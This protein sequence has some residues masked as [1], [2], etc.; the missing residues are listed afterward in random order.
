[1]RF[2]SW[3]RAVGQLLGMLVLSWLA[4]AIPAQSAQAVALVPCPVTTYDLSGRTYDHS[5]PYAAAHSEA[6]CD[7][8]VV[9]PPPSSAQGPPHLI[10]SVGFAANSD[11]LIQ[12]AN[13]DRGSG[14][15]FASE[16]TSPSGAKY[17]DVNAAR[18]ALPE[19][20]PL[21]ATGHHGGCAEFGCLLQAYEAEGVA[22]IRGGQMRTV[23]VRGPESPIPPGPPT[24]HGAPAA[25]CGKACQP[26][27]DHLGVGW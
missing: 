24:G 6:A 18:D 16:Y 12:F 1:M 8:V 13:A 10:P 3:P 15:R 26:L 19:G 21:N 9:A 11:P 7:G 20:H 17:Y 22:A 27:L 2:V 5:A 25:P 14:T 23:Y 4:L